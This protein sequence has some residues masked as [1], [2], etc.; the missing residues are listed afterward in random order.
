MYILKSPVFFKGK[1]APVGGWEIF[2]GGNL[3]KSDSD[4]FNF[5][6]S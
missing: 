2:G 4:H 6:E 1:N 5:L 3:T